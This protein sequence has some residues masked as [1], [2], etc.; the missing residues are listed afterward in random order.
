NTEAVAYPPS[1]RII[2]GGLIAISRGSLLAVL[3]F[4]RVPSIPPLMLM[5]AFTILTIV[6]GVA[7]WLI[8]RALAVTVQLGG[9]QLVLHHREQRIEVGLDAI[10]SV[11][12]WRVPL[13][14]S[15]LDVRFVSGRRLRYGLQ[16]SDP[17]ILIEALNAVAPSRDS[18]AL[19]HPSI[20]YARA[21]H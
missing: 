4:L 14:G 21:K 15:G 11:H 9:S 17:S 6:P 8:E 2:A 3:L 19:Q 18:V 16:L 12:P 10:A 5:R 1:W 7:L 20:I 13:P